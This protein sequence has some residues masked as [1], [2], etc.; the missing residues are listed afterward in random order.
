MNNHLVVLRQTGLVILENKY[1]S[2]LRDLHA[3]CIV[4]KNDERLWYY[5]IQ[6][7]NT[8]Q[9]GI[10]MKVWQSIQIR[11]LKLLKCYIDIY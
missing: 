10:T 8:D 11:L 7:L 4:G 1:R 3:L 9:I 6:K 5:S 2:I